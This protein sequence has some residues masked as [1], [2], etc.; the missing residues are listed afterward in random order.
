[1]NLIAWLLALTLMVTVMMEAVIFHQVTVCRQKAWL[2]STELMTRT[3]LTNPKNYAH[4]VDFACKLI[5]H[6]EQ[7]KVTWRRLPQLTT[8]QFQLP[9]KGHL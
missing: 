5:V 8:H 7:K 4:A 9:L 1:M 3:L 2:K 6:L